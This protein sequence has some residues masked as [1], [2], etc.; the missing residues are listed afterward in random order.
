LCCD[1]PRKLAEGEKVEDWTGFIKDKVIPFL[2]QMR[3]SKLLPHL[4]SIR[5][6]CTGN[7]PKRVRIVEVGPRDGLQNEAKLVGADEKIKLIEGLM[8]AGLKN[9]EAGS[10][11]NPAWVP[12]METTT[13]IFE[14]IN[15][16]GWN[17]KDVSFS[18]LTPNLKGFQAAQRLNVKEVA[19]FGAASE[20]FSK[21]NINCSISESLDRFRSVCDAAQESNIKV[22]GYVSC[23]LGCPYE[24]EIDPDIVTDVSRELL[25]MGCYEVSL[26]DTVGMGNP[27]STAKL[28]DSILKDI[29]IEQVAVHFH[30]TYGM[31]VAN[32]STAL[33]RGISVVDASVSG[34]GGCPYAAGATGNIA[35]EDVV[36]LLDGL[37]IDH[38]VDKSALLN[39]QK[40][41][42]KYL[43]RIS[44][45]KVVLANKGI[46]KKK[47][48]D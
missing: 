5:S 12:Q 11:V 1:P 35:T 33:E 6:I 45:S 23:V 4:Q 31:A 22:R 37:G 19:I 32:L 41:I 9:I 14:H 17:D 2:D 39:A 16:M 24:G 46:E 47:K 28:L 27:K 18:A 8:A 26:G 21:K 13:A 7:L 38:D 20:T 40:S 15:R 42:D 30:D 36:H 43:D 25:K 34:L 3:T 48:L 10:F 44:A 29:P